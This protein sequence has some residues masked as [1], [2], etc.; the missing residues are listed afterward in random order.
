MTTRR[1]T[2]GLLAE[3]ESAVDS[4]AAH[5]LSAGEDAGTLTELTARLRTIEERLGAVRLRLLTE[6]DDAGTW[7]IDGSRSFAHW[8][9]RTQ[10]VTLATAR[11]EVRTAKTLRDA[12]PATALAAVEGA[13]GAD[14]VRAMVDIAPTSQARRDALAAPVATDGAEEA[15][16][17]GT[18]ADTSAP[19]TGEEF[20][21]ALAGRYPVGPFRRMVRRF[22]HVADPESDERGYARA[23]EKEF[24]EVSP[25]WD[26]YHV[27]GFLTE[28]H[29]QVLRT[30]LD[31][32]VGAPA[33]A[34]TRTST[35]R[36][37]QG[38]AD[39]ARIALD[40]AAVGTGAS[41]RPH[42]NVT[43]GL[44]E[45]RAALAASDG[46]P[47]GATGN[48]SQ[49]ALV[50]GNAAGIDP[51]RIVGADSISEDGTA[52]VAT[53][54]AR[55]GYDLPG[56]GCHGSDG[57]GGDGPGGGGHNGGDGLPT[58]ADG[59]GP[60]PSSLLRRLA[61]DSELSRIVFGPDS[62]VL[63]VGRSRRTVTG[64]LRRAV[65]TRDRH[66]TWPG[67]EE[68]P[69]RCEVHHAVTHWADGGGTSVDNGALLCWHHHDRVDGQGVTMRW[70][71]GRWEFHDRFGNPIGTGREPHSDGLDGA[72]ERTHPA[73]REQ[74]TREH[75]EHQDQRE[76]A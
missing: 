4:L 22:A 63:D 7:A 59:R 25:T 64:Q 11:R 10:D 57:P 70:H 31:S 69:S 16:A 72:R 5:G 12:L 26:G 37:A 52:D 28:E 2:L 15:D 1:D 46:A 19:P 6:L 43:V 18:P 76:A 75:R 33:A 50:L 14:H 24:F 32:V 66:C 68:P 58:F 48:G 27:A 8:L 29:G 41:V 17:S 3:I 62:Q 74:E 44:T 56:G 40:N 49:G 51:R 23:R 30:A 21:L 47:P 73:F 61:C 65:I 36:R 71:R 55:R 35:Q 20:L 54:S 13:V 53:D 38:I 9:S 60:L 42:L 45:L 34:E 39:L 67:C